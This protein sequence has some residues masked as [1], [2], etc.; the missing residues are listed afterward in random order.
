M[1]FCQDAP[2]GKRDATRLVATAHDFRQTEI[3]TSVS[4]QS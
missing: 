2:I 1:S 3:C 4:V